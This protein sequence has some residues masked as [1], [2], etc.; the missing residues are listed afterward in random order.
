MT[1]NQLTKKGLVLIGAL[2][3]GM[4]CIY[5]FSKVPH[6]QHKQHSGLVNLNVYQNFKRNNP[7]GRT[8]L[9]W[10]SFFDRDDFN[11]GMETTP[12]L[13][14]PVKQCFT[15]ND[16]RLLNQSDAVIFHIR[17]LDMNDLPYM[18]LGHQR[19][20][21]YLL[22]S[23]INTFN[24]LQ[25]LTNMFN[26][27]MTYRQDSD[28]YRPYSTGIPYQQLLLSKEKDVESFR[29]LLAGKTKKVAWF[30][31]NCR[32][33]S[34]RELYVSRLKDHIDIDIYGACS[35]KK[36]PDRVP[37]YN[38]LAKDYK[39]YLA[40][41]NS[42]CRDYVTEKFFNSLRYSIVPIVLG[43]ANYSS[44][45]SNNSFINIA[46]FKSPRQLAEYLNWLDKNMTA[47][48]SYFSWRKKRTPRQVRPFCDLCQMLHNSSLPSR[49]YENIASWWYGQSHCSEY[50][51]NILRSSFWI[52]LSECD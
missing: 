19:W 25:K 31:S 48:E 45:I 20:I 6:L 27:T 33:D 38:M 32:T 13:K 52:H 17:D 50:K 36:C 4:I 15:T 9:F 14:C 35:T 21:F 10:T 22:E 40:F 28:I 1:Q 12:F 24:S 39:F 42:F 46:D 44:F 29:H 11:V 30:V 3:I 18:R 8:V 26:W 5:Y 49:S 7:S 16:R 43:G 2:T 47:Y 51:T 23:P 34:H 41:E 37:C